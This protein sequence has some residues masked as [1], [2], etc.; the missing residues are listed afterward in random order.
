M[1]LEHKVNSYNNVEITADCTRSR[2]ATPIS[3]QDFERL[4]WMSLQQWKKDGRK[5]VWVRIDKECVDLVPVAVRCGFSFHRADRDSIVLNAWIGSKDEENRMPLGPQFYVGCGGFVLNSKNQV[6][7]IQQKS[8]PSARMKGFWMLPGGLVDRGEDLKAAVVREV[9]EETGIDTEFVA[10]AAVRETH[11]TDTFGGIS[12]SG[13]TDF[14]C[15]CCLRILDEGQEIVVQESEISACKWMDLDE[16]LGSKYY[17][18]KGTVFHE[19]HHAAANVA[20]GLRDGLGGS[21]LKYGRSV[22]GSSTVYTTSN[23]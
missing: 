2:R 17:R 12:N 19:M 22:P 23:L 3:V 8:G 11:H 18:Q 21:T 5:G 14:Y 1:M 6:L 9:K 13:T 4:L 16:F 15:I 10:V 7:C 20:K